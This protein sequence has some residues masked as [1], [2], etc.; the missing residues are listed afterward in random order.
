MASNNRGVLILLLVIAIGTAYFLGTQKNKT[1][2]PTQTQELT[3]DFKIYSNT[4]ANWKTYTNNK[5]KFAF[6]YPPNSNIEVANATQNGGFSG[7]VNLVGA[8]IGRAN[9]TDIDLLTI[10]TG[11]YSSIEEFKKGN[12]S[13]S[14]D[15]PFKETVFNGE[16][17]VQHYYSGSVQSGGPTVVLFFIHNGIDYQIMYRYC[18]KAGTILSDSEITNMNPNILSTFR[19][20]DQTVNSDQ[21]AVN[22]LVKNFY[23]AIEAQ[24]GKLLFSYFTQP[25]T[26]AESESFK[27]LTGADLPGVPVYRVFFRQ[28]ISSPKIN[29]TQVND[30][31]FVVKISDQLTGVPSAGSETT[32][33]TPQPRNVVL[34]IIKSGDKWMADK[35]TDP[36]AKTGT[37]KYSGFAQGY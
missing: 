23:G 29:E 32:V 10:I 21:E 27:W 7:I 16:K 2:A 26:T 37:D 15:T 6:Q 30:T 14:P 13:F 12:T 25:S 1:P 11:N 19:F 35:F 28:K 3:P 34:T 20:S 33:Y 31:V 18:A 4:T 36:L 9:I 17:A 5:Y 22:N 8:C 24:D